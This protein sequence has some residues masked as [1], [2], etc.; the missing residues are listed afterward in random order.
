M[1]NDKTIETIINFAAVEIRLTKLVMRGKRLSESALNQE[2]TAVVKLV[3][4]YGLTDR[5]EVAKTVTVLME[6]LN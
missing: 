3:K 5:E 6:R 1:L 4:S 2:R